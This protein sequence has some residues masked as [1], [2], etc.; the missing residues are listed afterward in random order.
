MINVLKS[1]INSFAFNLFDKLGYSVSK[2]RHPEISEED[3]QLF[4][5]IKSLTMTPSDRIFA[6]MEAIKYVCAHNI[7]GDFVECGVWRG[8]NVVLAVDILKRFNKTD[9]NI[10][11]FD[12]FDGMVEPSDLDTSFK[13]EIAKNTF[14]KSSWAWAYCF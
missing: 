7:Q 14:S 4:E 2:I 8:G 5:K 13:G 11:L 10:W 6:L 9:K 3:W 12:T 1:K